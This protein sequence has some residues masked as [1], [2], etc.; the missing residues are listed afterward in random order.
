[1]NESQMMRKIVRNFKIYVK[2]NE[3]I[4]ED[5]ENHILDTWMENRDVPNDVLEELIDRK[6]FIFN[7]FYHYLKDKFPEKRKSISFSD[8]NM[9]AIY[10]NF[11]NL[12]DLDKIFT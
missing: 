11:E 5:F 1:M 2:N 6:G 7:E 3:W 4:K 12:I 9:Q 8:F 10:D